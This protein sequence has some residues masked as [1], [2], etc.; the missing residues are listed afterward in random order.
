MK[1]RFIPL[2]SF[3]SVLF[4]SLSGCYLNPKKVYP[5]PER[6][7]RDLALIVQT[8]Y[9]EYRPI[10]MRVDGKGDGEEVRIDDLGVTVLPGTYVFKA[11]L[12]RSRLEQS[13][14]IAT[15][16]VDPGKSDFPVE[17]SVLRWVRADEP[18]KETDDWELAVKAGFSYGLWCS[19]DDK[20]EMKVLGSHK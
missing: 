8:D 19:D 9:L 12:Y 7:K 20:I 10:Y 13:T 6:S 16:P 1:P 18:Y 5:G 3:F 17:Q 11:K 2:I 4:V 14:R 15:M